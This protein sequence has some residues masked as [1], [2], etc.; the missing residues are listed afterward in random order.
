M[1]KELTRARVLVLWFAFV[2]VTVAFSVVL[3]TSV[4]AG[5]A[6]VLAGLAIVPPAILLVMWP[7]VRSRTVAE[8]L[9]DLG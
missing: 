2:A 3:G 9:H 1:L 8:V 6:A 4:N 7:A 5:T